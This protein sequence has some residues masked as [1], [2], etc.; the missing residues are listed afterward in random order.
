ML[1][2]N[3]GYHKILENIYKKTKRT[4]LKINLVSCLKAIK[5]RRISHDLKNILID[6]TSKEDKS[7]YRL[8]R[9]SCSALFGNKKR[10]LSS[11]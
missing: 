11:K 4:L 7:G 5:M 9:L 1:F 8:K 6:K 10:N 3:K 2:N